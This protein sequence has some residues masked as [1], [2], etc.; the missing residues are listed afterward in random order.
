[1]ATG[2][3]IVGLGPGDPSLLTREAWQ[4]LSRAEEVYLRTGDYPVVEHLPSGLVLQTFDSLYIELDDFEAVY[5][6][7]VAKLLDLA[8]RPDGVVYAVPGDPTVGEA[9]VKTL[10]QTA[11]EAGLALRIVHGISFVEPCLA[12]VGIDALDGLY[13]ADA[14]ELATGHHPPFS[15]DSPALIGQLYSRLIAAEVKLTLMNQYPDDHPVQL[16]HAAGTP[17]AKVEAL[18]LHAVDRNPNIGGMTAL[19]LPPLPME[20]A[21]ESFQQ[22]VAHL[23]APGGCPWDREQTHKTL[24]TNLLEETYETLQAIDAED[25]TALREELGDLLLQI[26]LQTQIA[27]E[28]GDFSMAEVIAGIQA[29]I[30]RRHPHVF[31]DV[32]AV[33]VDHVL[34]NWEALKAAERQAE[35][36]GK[37]ILDGIPLGLP[38]LSQ[39]AEIQ[40]RVVRVGFD[41]PD[42]DGVQAKITEE[43]EEVQQAVDPKERSSEMGDL[44]FVVVNYAR[45]LGVDPEA[46][47]REANH[48]FRRRFSHLETVAEAEGRDLAGM[49]LEEMDVLWEEAKGRED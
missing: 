16:I 36:V 38:A 28:E 12:L 45:W 33:S 21:F 20:S 30:I 5:R 17:E 35:G 41:W 13:I 22:T 14:L 42:I 47:L 11:A 19:Y 24:R 9:T 4:M 15:P 29:K 34:H 32:S 3:T 40:E 6:A 10:R 39:A 7:I 27:T 23:R 48:R 25:M 43:L 46:A 18:P 37:G 44:L 2:I 49:T 8:N 1:M 26:V 31:G